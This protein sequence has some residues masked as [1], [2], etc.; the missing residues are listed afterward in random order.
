L[1][2]DGKVENEVEIRKR[3]LRVFNQKED[4]F[5]SVQ[6]YNDYLEEI[7]SVIYNLVRNHDIIKINKRLEQYKK[8]N[9]DYIIENRTK[10]GR[11]ELELEEL[12][13]EEKVKEESRRKA[14]AQEEHEERRNRLRAKEALI[15]Q[16][17]FSSGDASEIVKSFQQT[18]KFEK[19]L[20]PTVFSTGI[21]IGSLDHAFLLLPKVE[22]GE[23][24][25][26]EP[27]VMDLCG[28]PLPD[29][30]SIV[31]GEYRS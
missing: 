31:T 12:I 3:V 23:P 15:D 9:K 6:K 29:W 8:E 4:D 21:K 20:K 7:E 27:L 5:G 17:T 1:F 16:L 14:H 11:A 26:Y 18:Q 10:I 2:E 13:E 22:E 28:T 24:F 19:V 25:V 30:S